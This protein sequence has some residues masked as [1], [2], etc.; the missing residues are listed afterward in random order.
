MELIKDTDMAKKLNLS[1]YKLR[2]DRSE[3]RGIPFSKIGR[4][5]RYEV[6]KVSDYLL[7][8]KNTQRG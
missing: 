7:N 2:K 3:K 1:V 6:H 5:V 4:S 8:Q